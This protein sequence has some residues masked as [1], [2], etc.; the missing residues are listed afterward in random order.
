MRPA[1]IPAAVALILL[2]VGC[3]AGDEEG[4]ERAVTTTVTETVAADSDSTSTF[5]AIPDLVEEL[6]PSV[7]SI[8]LDDGEGSGVIVDEDTIV[9]N[10]HVAGEASEVQV[11]LASGRR[12]DASV[13]GADRC[14]DLALLSVP[15]GDLPGA[16]FADGLPRVGELAVAL[17]N[18][19]GFEN[20]VTAG[21]VSGLHRAIPSAGQTPALIDLIQTDA[22]ISPGNSGGA[23]VNARGEVIGINVAYIPPAA[24]AVAIGFAIP[25]PTVTDVIAQLERNGRVRHSFLGILP[26]QLTPQVADQFG[27]EAES[28]VL[29][30]SVTE[31]SPAAGAGLEEGD[32]IVA[33][34]GEDVRIVEDLLSRLREHEPGDRIALELVRA[35]E[36]REVEV[37]LADRTEGC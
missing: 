2:L 30:L 22:P 18:P 15:T 27:I 3:S 16:E 8:V 7:V 31:D 19:L 12:I 9:T 13:E 23:L 34:D 14:T 26:G 10:A 20:T 5:A 33:T 11:V 6:Q 37:T 24:R 36:R 4:R 35:D 25:S 28:G 29:V 21:I 32:L 17:G 1:S